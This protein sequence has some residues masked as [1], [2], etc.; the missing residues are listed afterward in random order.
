MTRILHKNGC[1]VSIRPAELTRYRDPR[2]IL[3]IPTLQEAR[4]F[5][6]TAL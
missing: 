3:S 2:L 5:A 1:D 4:M 6:W